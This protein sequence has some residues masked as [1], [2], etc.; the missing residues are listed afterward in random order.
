M[1]GRFNDHEFTYISPLGRS[2][3]DYM[4]VHYEELEYIRDFKII[5]MSGVINNINYVP[6]K[7]LDHSILVCEVSLKSEN[8]INTD[9]QNNSNSNWKFKLSN[10][11]RDF[12]NDPELSHGINETIERIQ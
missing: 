2:V 9:D 7:I 6:D 10:V 1:N 8:L 5:A 11:P 3:V 4:C 12:L